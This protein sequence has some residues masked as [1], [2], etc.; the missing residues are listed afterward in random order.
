[1]SQNRTPLVFVADANFL[2]RLID[3][4]HVH[5]ASAQRCLATLRGRGDEIRLVAQSLFEFYAVAARPSTARGGLALTSAEAARWMRAFTTLFPLEPETPLLANWQ[6]VVFTYATPGRDAH[7]A[8][9]VA[10][11]LS[12]GHTHILTFNTQDFLPF[13]PEGIVAVD[14]Q[15]V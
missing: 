15:T 11:M 9:Y 1:M 2:L 14:P 3:T 8:R 7:D 12:L 6:R 4:P 10:A 13:A 5:H